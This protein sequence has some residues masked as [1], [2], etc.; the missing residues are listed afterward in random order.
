MEAARYQAAEGLSDLGATT[1]QVPWSELNGEQLEELLFQLLRAMN[2]E[3]IIWRFGSV[4]GVATADD[5]R[6][7]EAVFSRTSPDGEFIRERWWIEC[8]SRSGTV[9]ISTVRS[10]V[11]S[12]DGAD[13]YVNNF[14]I[15]TNS[16]F[17]NP[18]HYHIERAQRK[19]PRRKG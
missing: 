12:R 8:K 15:A 19:A 18:A 2:P 5:G 11:A 3:R 6:D 14:A 7:I 4:N 10:A 9:G 13:D 16:K 17:S 1:T